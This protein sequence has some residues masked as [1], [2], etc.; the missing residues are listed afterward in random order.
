[1]RNTTIEPGIWRENWKSWKRRN[2]HS[3]M[4]NMTRKIEKSGKWEMH[5][6]GPGIWLEKRKKRGKW[7]KNTAWPG[8]WRETLKKVENEMHTVGP[9]VWL[10]NW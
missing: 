10:E 4:W 6:V 7:G 3:R 5:T 9:G 2:T 8:I 1:M